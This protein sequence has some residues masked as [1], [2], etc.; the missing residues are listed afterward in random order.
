[1]NSFPFKAGLKSVVRWSRGGNLA[2][3]I[4]SLMPKNGVFL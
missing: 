4:L 1:M 3:T 2:R